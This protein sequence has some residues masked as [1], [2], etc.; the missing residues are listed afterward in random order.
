M[1]SKI[2][3]IWEWLI[4]DFERATLSIF[5]GRLSLQAQLV[6]VY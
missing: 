2:I 3:K 5:M 1:M 6:P 4:I